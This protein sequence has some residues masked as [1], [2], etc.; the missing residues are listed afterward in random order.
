MSITSS[1]LI[2]STTAVNHGP[3]L[4]V[5]LGPRLSPL[6]QVISVA[7]TREPSAVFTK[8]ERWRCDP[9]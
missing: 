7:P 1:S 4:R 3:H 6:S 5:S 8:M 2:Q 9:E